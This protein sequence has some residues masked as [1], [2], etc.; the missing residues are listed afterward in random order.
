MLHIRDIVVGLF[1]LAGLEEDEDLLYAC[2]MDVR[3]MCIC[4]FGYRGICVYVF[5]CK[6]VFV[7][8]CTC[9]SMYLCIQILELV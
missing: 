3:L 1:R 8:L 7:F 2:T 4:E 6:C 9:V 5:L